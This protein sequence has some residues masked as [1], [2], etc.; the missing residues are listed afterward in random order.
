MDNHDWCKLFQLVQVLSNDF[1]DQQ[2]RGHIWS[3][4]RSFLS[5]LASMCSHLIGVGMVWIRQRTET[6]S[7]GHK[8]HVSFRSSSNVSAML[9]HSLAVFIISHNWLV[10]GV[11]SVLPLY[12]IHRIVREETLMVELFGQNYIDYHQKVGALWPWKVCGRDLGLTQREMELILS[13]RDKQD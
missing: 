1:R 3:L 7:A 12:G 5:G 13:Q 10:G 2:K 9:L 11:V 8:W 4:S 6:P